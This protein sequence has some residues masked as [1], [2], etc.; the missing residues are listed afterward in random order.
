MF[1]KGEIDMLIADL[2]HSCSNEKVA[3]AAL[4]CIGGRFVDRVRA[5]AHDKGMDVGRFGV[6]VVNDF[7][8]RADAIARESLREKISGADQ[9]LLAALRT[10][11]EPALEDGVVFF[12]DDAAFAHQIMCDISYAG[13]HRFQ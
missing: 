12:D 4:Y 2:I 5:A 11:L 1:M 3:Q 10:V 9:P 6:V 13:L 7:S 8:R